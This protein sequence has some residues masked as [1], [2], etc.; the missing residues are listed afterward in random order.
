MD[1]YLPVLLGMDAAKQIRNL[2]KQKLKKYIEPVIIV[3]LTASNSIEDKRKI[4]ISGCYFYL[5][6]S[7][8]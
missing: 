1:L 7:V 6:K 2:G 4:L 5:T 8:N 3:N